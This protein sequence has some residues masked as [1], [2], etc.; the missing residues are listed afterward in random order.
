MWVAYPAG[1]PTIRRT[2][3]DGCFVGSLSAAG[4]AARRRPRTGVP[5]ATRAP[6][7]LYPVPASIRLNAGILDHFAPVNELGLHVVSQLL[8]RAG[9]S[10]EAYVLEFCLHIR[11]VDD[12]AQRP[13]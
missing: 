5:S 8:R 6:R 4:L 7:V 1:K 13:V 12:L 9:K 3:R 2:G 11:A 10:L